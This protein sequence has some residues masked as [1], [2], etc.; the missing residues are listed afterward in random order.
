MINIILTEKI[1]LFLNACKYAGEGGLEKLRKDASE[2]LKEIDDNS[3]KS[4]MEQW[5]NDQD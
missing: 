3:T 1:I 5:W 4:A 2:L